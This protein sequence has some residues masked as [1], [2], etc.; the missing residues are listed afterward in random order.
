M[1]TL[2][3]LLTLA[4]TLLTATPM[5]AQTSAH[6]PRLKAGSG[7][8]RPMAPSTG[9][10]PDIPPRFP[11]D[12]KAL[13][14]FLKDNL[15]YPAA[16]AD[17]QVSGHVTVQFMVQ[18][19]GSLTDFGIVGDTLGYGCEQEALRVAKLMPKWS[20]ARRRTQPVATATLITMPFGA[21]PTLIDPKHRHQK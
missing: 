6:P 16:A 14:Q 21:S 2:L 3:P 7:V 9:Y 10:R 5:L 1:R 4:A 11:G 12:Q 18:E 17:H 20:P 8:P 15:Q 13:Q 19:D